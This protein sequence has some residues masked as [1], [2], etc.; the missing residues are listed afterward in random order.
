VKLD[1]NHPL[2]ARATSAVKRPRSTEEVLAE[3]TAT[4]EASSSPTLVHPTYLELPYPPSANTLYRSQIVK[5]KA[6]GKHIAIP[7]KT[8]EHKEYMA[9]VGDVVGVLA[10]PWPIEVELRVDVTLFRPMR[11]GD[12]DGPV[13]A[14]LDA[15]N[16]RAWSDD[17][18]LVELHLVR[19][20]DKHRPRVELRITAVTTTPEEP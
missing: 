11:R 3:V 18:Q 17:S 13:K 16:G 5:S 20:D 2:A 1:P 12:I 10:A 9:A 8:T 14:L 15:L 4:I 7:F 6:T 19:R